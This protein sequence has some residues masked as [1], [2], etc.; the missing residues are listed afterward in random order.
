MPCTAIDLNE[1]FNLGPVSLAAFERS[2]TFV[3]SSTQQMARAPALEYGP[4]D[5]FFL[6][7]THL[8]RDQDVLIPPRAKTS[9]SE[10]D[11]RP[12]A[13]PNFLATARHR[14]IY[15]FYRERDGAYY[16]LWP[17]HPFF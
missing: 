12:R 8:V 14:P 1:A 5:Q 4:S 2:A 15:A 16:A 11:N 3:T 6:L 13:P 7:L 17:S 9:A 10:T